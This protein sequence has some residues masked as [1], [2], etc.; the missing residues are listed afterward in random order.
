MLIVFSRSALSPTCLVFRAS[1]RRKKLARLDVDA[2]NFPKSS[3]SG[4]IRDRVQF[5]IPR[6]SQVRDFSILLLLRRGS[7]EGSCRKFA[8]DQ[9]G[10][11]AARVFAFFV[12]VLR[13]DC[14][15]QGK[16]EFGIGSLV[17]Y[18]LV[19]HVEQRVKEDWRT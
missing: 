1:P 4:R 5:L 16:K 12:L 13:N 14:R 17:G 6:V 15:S 2:A 18:V 9:P 7:D 11:V 19:L 3:S 8:R 10:Q